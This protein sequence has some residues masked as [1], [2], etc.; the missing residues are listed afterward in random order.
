VVEL[1]AAASWDR[2]SAA[3]RVSAPAAVVK[4]R[5]FRTDKK[6][7]KRFFDENKTATNRFDEA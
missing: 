6:K 5:F 4:K 7:V 1:A 3:A 2:P